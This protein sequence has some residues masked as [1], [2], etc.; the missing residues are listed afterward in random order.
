M[1]RLVLTLST[2]LVACTGP[3]DLDRFL[4]DCGNAI[5]DGPE[6]CDDGNRINSDGCNAACRLELGYV[7]TSSAGTGRSLC[8][9]EC[10]DGLRI[11]GEACDD[12]DLEG[13]DGCS[14]QCTV[15]SGWSCDRGE[16]SFCAGICGDGR[17]IGLEVCDDGND[18]NDDGC[19]RGCAV[20]M[21]FTCNQSEPSR[22]TFVCGD[23]RL[24][25]GEVCDDGNMID[26]D[27]CTSMT[28]TVEPGWSCLPGEMG[29]PSR[30][31]EC[32]DGNIGGTEVC[33][34]SNRS[35]GDGC[36]PMCTVEEGWNCSGNPSVCAAIC[37]DGLALGMEGCDD[38][39]LEPLDGCNDV[40]AVEEGW[41]CQTTTG[42]TSVC[43]PHWDQRVIPVAVPD[44]HSGVF[45]GQELIVFGGGEVGV[46]AVST[47]QRYDP[48]LDTWQLLPSANAPSGRLFH[49]AVWTGADMIVFGGA[50][51]SDELGNGGRFVLADNRWLPIVQPGIN[52]GRSQHTAVWTGVE[53]IVHGGRGTGG[54]RDDG[55]RYNPS[56][57][58]WTTTSPSG[59]Q[60]TLHSAVWMESEMFV[61]GGVTAVGG[62]AQAIDAPV[63]YNPN[64][65]Q[66]RSL[67]PAPLA[68]RF[69]AQA[70]W[71]G[72][73]VVVFGGQDT[74][75][76]PFGDGA[77]YNPTTN[78]W[79]LL[80]SSGAPTPGFDHRMA[81]GG[82][83]VLVIGGNRETAYGAR[84]RSADNMWRPITNVLAPND[85]AP[86]PS[87]AWVGSGL[88]VVGRVQAGLYRVPPDTSEP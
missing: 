4:S 54:F 3:V 52:T 84:W 50:D 51:V 53:M 21:G 72:T 56:R 20:E 12:A 44:F 23:G 88:L 46:T 80:P 85:D 10:G 38:A 55:F 66:W 75:D 47:G 2:I 42:T 9:P 22:C 48:A 34:D 70:V 30:C 6:Q 18:V 33:D 27:G 65:D 58:S 71:T 7:C 39:N 16:P 41:L 67:A 14:A 64:T 45:T 87:V 68:S 26:G 79:T 40:C 69:S 63:A 76:T 83:E 81:F 61:F 57:D 11:S 77:R 43:S 78:V 29:G 19:S 86:T 49:T 37:G 17:V 74:N 28:C 8:D 73:E 32:G 24:V 36:S 15:E 25:L 31:F 82:G 35:A 60:R 62:E 1:R 13:G 5:V 59:M